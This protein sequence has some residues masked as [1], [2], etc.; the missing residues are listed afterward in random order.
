V[1]KTET[2]ELGMPSTP[3]FKEPTKLAGPN[4]DPEKPW[5]WHKVEAQNPDIFISTMHGNRQHG[6]ISIFGNVD[7]S[8]SSMPK[9]LVI[10]TAVNSIRN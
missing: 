6:V 9:T 8:I 2:I 1:Y 3:G 10:S 7:F 5:C 4:L